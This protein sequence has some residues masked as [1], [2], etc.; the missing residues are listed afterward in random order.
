MS[1]VIQTSTGDDKANSASASQIYIPV[2]HPSLKGRAQSGRTSF[3]NLEA[4][5]PL[6]AVE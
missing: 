2:Y 1:L 4:M 6:E 5:A 3:P